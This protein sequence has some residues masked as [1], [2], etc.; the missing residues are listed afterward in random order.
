LSSWVVDS[1]AVEGNIKRL[2][3]IEWVRVRDQINNRN[4]NINTVALYHCHVCLHNPCKLQA[5]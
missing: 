3:L 5:S 4:E 1:N 2:G